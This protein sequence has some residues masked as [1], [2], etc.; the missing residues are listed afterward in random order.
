MSIVIFGK[1]TWN[2]NFLASFKMFE[3][4]MKTLTTELLIVI[5]RQVTLPS[6]KW[7]DVSLG[8]STRYLSM[9]LKEF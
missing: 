8:L 6:N 4:E 1:L 9:K 2:I 3:C 5:E 7:S